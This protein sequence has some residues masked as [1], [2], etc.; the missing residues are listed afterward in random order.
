MQSSDLWKG[1]A[2]KTGSPRAFSSEQCHCQ[3]PD[4]RVQGSWSGDWVGEPHTGS[5]YLDND[6]QKLKSWY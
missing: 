2:L 4:S 5:P 3:A 6:K 1:L